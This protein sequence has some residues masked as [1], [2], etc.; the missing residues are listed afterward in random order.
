MASS[1]AVS[2]EVVPL[3]TF[4]IFRDSN[5]IGGYRTAANVTARNA[6]PTAARLEGMLVYC[7]TEAKTYRLG[8]G[9]LDADWVES[10]GGAPLPA[11]FYASS[12]APAGGDGSSSA[13]YDSLADALADHPE[14]GNTFLCENGS[15]F[16]GDSTLALTT[17]QVSAIVSRDARVLIGSPVYLP[18]VTI[19]AGQSVQL[20]GLALQDVT[21]LST[22][23]GVACSGCVIDGAVTA[24]SVQL[25]QSYTGDDITCAGFASESSVVDGAIVASTRADLVNSTATSIDSPIVTIDGQTFGY[26]PIELSMPT[27]GV[28]TARN[29]AVSFKL[30][31]THTVNLSGVAWNID[32]A[33]VLPNT[34]AQFMVDASTVDKTW[35]TLAQE[36]NVTVTGPTL[37]N[38]DPDAGILSS[39][40]QVTKLVHITSATEDF[41]IVSMMRVHHTGLQWTK[42]LFNDTDYWM[43]LAEDDGITGAATYRFK[44]RVV[45]PP[46]GKVL[47]QYEDTSHRWLAT[48]LSRGV[49]Y[50]APALTDGGAD[51]ALDDSA[52][53]IKY[54]DDGTGLAPLQKDFLEW[55]GDVLRVTMTGSFSA[56]AGNAILGIQYALDA[57]AVPIDAI[58]IAAEQQVFAAGTPFCV[59][60]TKLVTGTTPPSVR[61]TYRTSGTTRI[62]KGLQIEVE[63]IP[64]HL[65]QGGLPT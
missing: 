57:W 50:M 28:L 49:E 23:E 7:R 48:N 13:A 29:C 24:A 41:T 3:G 30:D 63:R 58:G 35:S 65:W 61:G 51:S 52:A 60:G 2:D 56:G 37:T 64:I 38:W 22:G 10:V 46:K 27:L 12:A 55:N 19:A 44:N 34:G 5:F 36:M 25:I 47:V 18:N 54:L 32:P 20:T 31:D 40:F 14:S 39:G 45:V 15:D 11:T 8:A 4:P 6:I 42:T 9:L 62:I 17:C 43:T 59:R 26:D 21:G 1:V 53:S 16:T 33:S